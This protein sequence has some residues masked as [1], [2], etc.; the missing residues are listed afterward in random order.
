MKTSFKFNFNLIT[1]YVFYIFVFFLSWQTRYI[2][3]YL[4]LNNQ[5]YEYGKLSFYFS[6]LIFLI[7]I[8][9]FILSGKKKDKL[10]RIF[11]YSF[12][13]LVLA[14][15]NYLFALNLELYFY[16][17]FKLTECIIFFFI[18]QKI[19]F[20]KFKLIYVFIC[21]IFL[22]CVLAIFQFVNQYVFP[23]KYLGISEQLS[24]LGGVSVVSNISGR[25]LRVYGGFSHP[26]IFAGFLS[27]AIL[28]MVFVY[29]KKYRDLGIFKKGIFWFVLSV[30]LYCLCITFSRSAILALFISFF[31][32]FAFSLYSKNLKKIYPVILVAI[33][34]LITNFF[35]FRDLFYTRLGNED[36]LEIKSY[37]ERSVLMNQS[38]QLV[39][40]DYIGG[41]GL[42]NYVYAVNNKIDNTLS[43]WDY[44]PV[45]NVYVLVLCEMGVL[46]FIVY[47]MI[48]VFKILEHI[49]S[50][51]FENYI[52]LSILILILIISL[53][54][55]YFWTS[56]SSLILLFLILSLKEDRNI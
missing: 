1:E 20:D 37:N 21:S 19:N 31:I 28:L 55:H 14:S 25:F 44:Q 48:F 18:L 11:L 50:K 26:N 34:I 16:G 13:F 15:I 12:L 6:E 43:I 53:F 24:Y 39:K 22:N 54:D 7:L 35:I 8:F 40:N 27:I 33:F 56:W 29:F 5:I 47:F 49:R 45:H 52:F 4:T 46:G 9:V 3:E 17:L 41:I 2:Y 10:S 32:I 23:S 38:L 51:N 30:F 42:N 36:R